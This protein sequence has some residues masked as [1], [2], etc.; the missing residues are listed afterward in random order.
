M[1]NMCS[2]YQ[3]KMI[4]IIYGE[5]IME[6]TLEMHIK[7]CTRCR[8]YWEDLNEM[9]EELTKLDIHVPIEYSKISFAFEKAEE[10]KNN[11]FKNKEFF[12]FIMVCSMILLSLVILSLQGYLKQV[13]YL[14]IGL[15]FIVPI[16]LP[17]IIKIRSVKER[18]NE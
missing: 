12:L 9:K 8:K 14:Q 6:Q 5:D 1:N 11:R 18:Y 10:I 7:K 3:S 17:V 15:Y 16:F 13:V 2:K 4:D